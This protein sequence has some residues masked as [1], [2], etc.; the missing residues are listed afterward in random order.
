VAI[1]IT[2]GIQKGGCGKTLTSGILAHLLSQRG[3]K[4]LAVDMDSQGNLTQLLTEVE[5]IYVFRGRTI[6]DAVKN[7]LSEDHIVVVDDNLHIIPSNDLLA[8]Y[9]SYIATAKAKN[10]TNFDFNMTLSYVLAPVQDRYDFI[11]IDTPP[12]LSE[13]TLNSMAASDYIITMFEASNFC[14]AA[15]PRYFETYIRLKEKVNPN[16]KMLGVVR[17]LIDV[18]RVDNNMLIN[19]IDEMI[20][21]VCFRNIIN[22]TAA[23]GRI[24]LRGFKNN[25]ELKKALEQHEVLLDEILGRIVEE[26]DYFGKI[27]NTIEDYLVKDFERLEQLEKQMN[28]R[29]EGEVVDG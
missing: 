27:D 6:M 11:I 12:A 28:T 25:D 7:G 14:L 24:G 19:T 16:L 29:V 20:E 1:T 26:D 21:G 18:R 17:T 13:Q 22:R 9:S 15:I 5:D 23:V 8:L 3:Y 10:S 4:V 2:V